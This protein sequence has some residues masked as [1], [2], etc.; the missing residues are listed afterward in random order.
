MKSRY[1]G[2]FSLCVFT[3]GF[4][5]DAQ[6]P[7]KSQASSAAEAQAYLDDGSMAQAYLDITSMAQMDSVVADIIA[8]MH[9]RFTA[10][11]QNGTQKISPPH[12][13]N[14]C[15]SKSPPQFWRPIPH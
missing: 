4:V 2:I 6:T 7:P 10:I 3:C 15:V 14:I 8:S 1:I 9:E 12:S 5:L 11:S 13:A